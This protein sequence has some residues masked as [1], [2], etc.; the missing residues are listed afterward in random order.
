MDNTKLNATHAGILNDLNA[1]EPGSPEFQTYMTKLQA[2]TAAF[3]SLVSALNEAGFDTS[4][5]SYDDTANFLKELSLEGAEAYAVS[6]ISKIHSCYENTI[7]LEAEAVANSGLSSEKLA[8]FNKVIGFIEGLMST[9]SK[10]ESDMSDLRA[11]VFSQ[12]TS[13]TVSQPQ[14]MSGSA[15]QRAMLEIFTVGA[16]GKIPNTLGPDTQVFIKGL[17]QIMSMP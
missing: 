13:S 14:V 16:T 15:S 5:M 17:K 11:L 2:K 1:P 8:A 10:I 12:A 3:D 4:N 6:L 7:R 9:Q